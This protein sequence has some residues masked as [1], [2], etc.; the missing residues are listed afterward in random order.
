M[1]VAVDWSRRVRPQPG[2]CV[3]RVRGLDDLVR[4]NASPPRVRVEVAALELAHRAADDLAAISVLA[5]AVGGRRT[6]AARLREAMTARSRLRRR[7]LLTGLVED[8]DAG[9]H[10]VLEHGFLVRVVRPHALP[11]P[12]A[13][14]GPRTG[15]RGREYR[16]A[17]YDALGLTVELDGITHD[18]PAARAD[19]ADRDLDDL[20]AGRVVGRLRYRQVF[21]TPCRTAGLLG[22]VLRARGWEGGPVPCGPDCELAGAA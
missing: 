4:W 9:T 12:D 8:L 20:A 5:E 22:A 1:H 11:E 6:N 13:R 19:D 18:T 17:D 14:Q 16:D 15:L 7:S 10:S 2:L 3:H 21:G